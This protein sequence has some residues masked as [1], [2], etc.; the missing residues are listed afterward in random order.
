MH[1]NILVDSYLSSKYPPFMSWHTSV[2]GSNLPSSLQ[3]LPDFAVKVLTGLVLARAELGTALHFIN[4]SADEK[5][6]HLNLQS[7]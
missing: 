1:N 7:I 3:N 5:Y 2:F 6:S 4:A